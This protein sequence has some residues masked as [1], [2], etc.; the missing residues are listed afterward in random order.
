MSSASSR[1]LAPP[2]NRAISS[3][4]P[5]TL[6]RGDDNCCLHAS[7]TSDPWLCPQLTAGTVTPTCTHT[8]QLVRAREEETIA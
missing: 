4:H 6:V 1:R 5:A 3:S 7:F 2:S 8:F